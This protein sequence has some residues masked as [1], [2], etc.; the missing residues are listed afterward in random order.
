MRQSDL[1]ELGVEE[2]AHRLGGELG[3]AC[4]VRDAALQV[5]VC[6]QC[7]RRQKAWLRDEDQVVVLREIFEE[8]TQ[9]LPADLTSYAPTN[10]PS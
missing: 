8:K 10:F 3:D 6:A 5:F 9:L 4:R 2:V 7:E 1:V